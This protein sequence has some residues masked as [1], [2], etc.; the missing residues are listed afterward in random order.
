LV[1]SLALTTE[2]IGGTVE[3]TESLLLTAGLHPQ[4]IFINS[5]VPLGGLEPDEVIARSEAFFDARNYRYELWTDRT[6][7]A[8][9]AAAQRAGL[10]FCIEMAVMVTSAPPPVPVDIE[11]RLA[12]GA[13]GLE[14][15][16][17]VS[18]EVYLDDEDVPEFPEMI[19]ATYHSPESLLHEDTAVVIAYIDE[20]PA[21]TATTFTVGETTYVCW[22]GTRPAYRRRGL[23]AAV[24][25]RAVQAGFGRGATLA[26]LEATPDGRP[27]YERLGFTAIGACRNYWHFDQGAG[28]RAPWDR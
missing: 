14:D 2:R 26:V 19:R 17:T 20:R 3:R 8:Y 10:A 22:V 21:A 28:V 5:A 7:D 11:M 13:Q 23:G 12:V 1:D 15:F 16:L 24:T 4:G 18:Q 9:A 27:V 6:D 25:A